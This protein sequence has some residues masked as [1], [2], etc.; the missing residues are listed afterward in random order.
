MTGQRFRTAN[1]IDGCNREG[2]GINVSFSLPSRRITKWLDS[3][4]SVGGYPTAIRVDNALEN[5]SKHFQEWVQTHN[6]EIKFIQPG[7]PAQNR[8]IERFNRTY[9]E[10]SFDLFLFR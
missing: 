7:K 5:I 2:L 4:A 6:I 8:Y 10:A 1:V 9:R 3:I